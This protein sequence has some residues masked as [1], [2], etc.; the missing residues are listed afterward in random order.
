MNYQD[1]LDFWFAPDH[2]NFWFA[3][4]SLFDD[5]IRTHFSTV[6]Q[7][8]TQAE[9]WSWRQTVEGRLAEIIVLDQFSRNLYRDQAQAFAQDSMALALAQEAI[10]QQLDAQLSPEQRSFLYMPFM[11]SESKLIHEFALKLFQKLGNE[12]NLSFEKKHKV[13]ID[14]FG[15]YPHRNAILGRQSTPEELEFLTQ[16]NSHF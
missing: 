1:V 16:P 4:D 12:I 14:Q 3:K 11:H 9:L 2:T 6:H 5:E 15:R 8:A 10:T 7:Q 13:I